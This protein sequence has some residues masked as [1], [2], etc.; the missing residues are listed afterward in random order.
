MDGFSKWGGVQETLKTTVSI[1]RFPK[2]PDGITSST[3][4]RL[5]E[6]FTLRAYGLLTMVPEAPTLNRA[7]SV[8]IPHL[9]NFFFSLLFGFFYGDDF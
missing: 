5:P 3:G 1:R 4:G 8:A 6:A 9:T 2:A 7:Q